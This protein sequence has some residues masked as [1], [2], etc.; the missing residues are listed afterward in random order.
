MLN[1]VAKLLVV[2]PI[3]VLFFAAAASFIYAIDSSIKASRHI[4]AHEDDLPL[5]LRWN[6]LNAIYYP[7]LLDS[8]GRKDR[9]TAILWIIGVLVTGILLIL[10][11][12]WVRNFAGY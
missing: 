4:V 7:D 9:R 10:Y 5:L 6:K 1:D 12:R 3:G 8:E 2:L 11:V